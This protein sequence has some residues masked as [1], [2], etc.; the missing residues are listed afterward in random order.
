[1]LRKFKKEIRK[2]VWRRV[3]SVKRYRE[4]LE[5]DVIRKEIHIKFVFRDVRPRSTLCEQLT[6]FKTNVSL[7]LVPDFHIVHRIFCYIV[8]RI[9]FHFV[10]RIVFHIVFRIVFR[11][12]FHRMGILL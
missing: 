1:M 11:I 8:F 12:V 7:V 10:F 2:A 5:K 3:P 9:S 4:L 6:L